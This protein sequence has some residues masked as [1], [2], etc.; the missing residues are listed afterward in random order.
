MGYVRLKHTLSALALDAL[1]HRARHGLPDPTTPVGPDAADPGAAA[2][3]EAVSPALVAARVWLDTHGTTPDLAVTRTRSRR[4]LEARRAELEA[5]FA[6]VPADHRRFID[7]L[8]TGGMLPLEDT[9]ELLREALANRGERRRW[10]L[11]HWPHVVEY[12]QIT[13]TLAHGLAGPDVPRLLT[14]LAAS[15]HRQL[16]AAAD[17]G[18][19]W[20]VTLTGQLVAPDAASADPATQRLLAD[21]A[22]YRHRWAV[23]G[24][25][26]LGEG[27]FDVDQA[28]ERTVLTL[29]INHAA[30]DALLDLHDRWDVHPLEG[31]LPELDDTLS[32]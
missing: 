20:L 32:R 29:A 11:E 27:T 8:Q 19:A 26:P 5:I 1:A 21:V 12:A 28:A 24:A 3:W 17:A 22:G 13:R 23:T 4:E 25:T 31:R 6:T 18:E 30:G 15:P 9:T 2:V 10:I 16:A 7:R 14:T